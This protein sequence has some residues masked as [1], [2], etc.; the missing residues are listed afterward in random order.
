MKTRKSLPLRPRTLALAMALSWTA[1][2][3]LA[4]DTFAPLGDL[5]GSFSV[6]NGVSANGSV[7]AGRSFLAGGASRAFRWT[8]GT[9]S[10]LGTLGGTHSEAQGVSG[11]GNVIVGNSIAAD[12]NLYAFRWTSTAGM[13][14]LPNFEGGTYSRAYG[15]SFDGNVIVGQ[16]DIATGSDFHAIRWVA[17]VATD[18]G[19][20]G[21]GSSIAFGVSDHG[22]VVVGN[23]NAQATP[24]A[25]RWVE[26]AE[27]GVAGNVQMRALASLDGGAFT[28]TSAAAVSADGNVVVGSSETSAFSGT[29]HA[30]RWAG[31]DMAITDLGTLPGMTGSFAT[32]T[33]G[34]GSVVVGASGLAFR[35]TRATGMQAVTTWLAGAGVSPPANWSLDVANGVNGNG[36]VVVGYGTDASGN[37]QAWLA[38]VGDAGTGLITD[39]NAFNATLAEAG[40]GTTWVIMG[41]MFGMVS[42]G[43]HHRS[44]FDNGLAR[45]G[46]DGACGWATVDA[47]GQNH[48]DTRMESA[49]VGACKDIGSTRL[50][51]G[52]GQ[53]WARQDWSLDGSARLDGQYLIAEVD[54][55]FNNGPEASVLGL[56]GRFGTRLD[57]RYTNGAAV[58]SSIA[59]PDATATALRLR[60]DWKNVAQLASFGLSPYAA[61]SWGNTRVKGYTETGGGFPAQFAANQS[62]VHDLRLGVAAKTALS[63]A[64]DLRLGLEAAHRFE[65]NING[66]NGQALGLPGLSFSLPGQTQK[67]NWMRAIVDVDHR[68]SNATALTFG[69]SA[70][71]TGGDATW[72]VTAG[73]RASF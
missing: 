40:T 66:A 19:T 64:S 1:F 11:D 31:G 43:G 7:V 14:A 27:D 34:D 36:N 38:R 39:I 54:H 52:V 17:G 12:T 18:L 73:L 57:R 49:E 48:S 67:Q 29:S 2:A 62:T 24:H 6:A 23:S 50:G 63:G 30:T 47:G 65:D 20:L 55:A 44:L 56:Y 21:V 46:A 61:Y 9:L 68:L 60:L 72:G 13:T 32:A 45:K 58:D 3:T 4:A 41:P 42:S 35:W 25:F 33:S 51:L 59:S 69:A 37:P 22:N 28:A 26:G 70:A 16:G 15:A 53:A 8:G 5:G 10:D 71:T